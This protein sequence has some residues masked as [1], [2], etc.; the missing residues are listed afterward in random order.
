MAYRKK[1]KVTKQVY[2]IRL[3]RE[4]YEFMRVQGKMAGM[5]IGKLISYWVS[6]KRRTEAK[7]ERERKHRGMF[8]L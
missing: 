5:S 6:Q 7:R 1:E 2:S 8:K 4:D 3:T